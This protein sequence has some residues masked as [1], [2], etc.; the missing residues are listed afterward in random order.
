MCPP[1]KNRRA[2]ARQ[3]HEYGLGIDLSADLRIGNGRREII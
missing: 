1:L 3:R 2:R